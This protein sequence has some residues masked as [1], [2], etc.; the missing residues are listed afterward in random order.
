M[1]I[2]SSAFPSSSSSM[3]IGSSLSSKVINHIV[4]KEVNETTSPSTK[5]ILFLGIVAGVNDVTTPNNKDFIIL[6][7]SANTFKIIN[8]LCTYIV[9]LIFGLTISAPCIVHIVILVSVR[10]KK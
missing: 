4:S 7:R 10:D 8:E 3:V 2:G 6:L 5:E 1:V 9:I